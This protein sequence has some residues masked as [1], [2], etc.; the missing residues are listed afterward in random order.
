MGGFIYKKNKNLNIVYD[1]GWQKYHCQS[2]SHNHS[3]KR[4]IH[5]TVLLYK[6]GI[7]SFLV[8]TTEI[9][10]VRTVFLSVSV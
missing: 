1:L 10:G 5:Y 9:V 7:Y 4:E 8:F 6:A 3:E 2:A